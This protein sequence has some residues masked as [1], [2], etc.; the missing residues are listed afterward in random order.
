MPDNYVW[1]VY[2][3]TLIHQDSFE[4]VIDFK[5]CEEYGYPPVDQLIQ[6]DAQANWLDFHILRLSTGRHKHGNRR[7]AGLWAKWG[8]CPPRTHRVR[9]AYI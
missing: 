9:P 5:S 3:A 8:I 6:L 1:K 2:W 4:L 7:G